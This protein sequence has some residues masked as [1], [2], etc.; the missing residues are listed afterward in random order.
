[1]DNPACYETCSIKRKIVILQPNSSNRAMTEQALGQYYFLDPQCPVN[2]S[3]VARRKL[4]THDHDLTEI[5]H[6]HDFIELVFIMHG[7]GVQVLSLIHISEP[8]RHG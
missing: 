2:L 8:T 1:M 4:L 3:K 5:E 6:Y 7:Q